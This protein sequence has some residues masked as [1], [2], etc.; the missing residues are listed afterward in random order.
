MAKAEYGD[1][2]Y[3]KHNLYRHYGIYINENCVVHYDG[4]LDDM[5]LRKMCIRETT[6]DRFLGGKTSYYIDNREA[7]FNN[8]E[9]VERA[10]ECIGEEKFN[11][12]S[13][14]CEHF[15]MWCKAGEPRSKQVYL[16]LLLAITINSCLNNKGVVQNKM[17]I[18]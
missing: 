4:K 16:T 5:F 6:M 12:V 3:T 18:I 1:I 2:I 7:K 11:L 13:H 8:K 14:N 10:R 17:D 9:V 15:A